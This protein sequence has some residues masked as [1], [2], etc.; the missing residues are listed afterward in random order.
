[1]RHH[2]VLPLLVFFSSATAQ[3]PSVN[4]SLVCPPSAL[5]KANAS[6][7]VTFD[8][9]QIE[10]TNGDSNQNL[11]WAMTVDEGSQTGYNNV[12]FP[13]FDTSIWIGQPPSLNLYY[14]ENAFSAC[15]YTFWDLPIN[16]IE[17]GQDDDGSCYQ[18]FSEACVTALTDQVANFA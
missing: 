9:Y 10:S 11:S 5:D 7:P 2:S 15:A 17:R 8:P 4:Q 6:G 14:G 1:M 3:F 13:T 16:T 18:T 12:S